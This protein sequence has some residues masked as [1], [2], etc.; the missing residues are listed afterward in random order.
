[1]KTPLKLAIDLVERDLTI[2][3]ESVGKDNPLYSARTKVLSAAKDSID[4]RAFIESHE[5]TSA[6]V[7]DTSM[8]RYWSKDKV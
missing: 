7:A 4:L 3:V 5:L 1:M 8:N 6:Y 2:D